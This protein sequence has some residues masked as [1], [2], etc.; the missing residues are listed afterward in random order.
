MCARAASLLLLT[1]TAAGDVRRQR[2][3]RRGGRVCV[4]WCVLPEARLTPDHSAEDGNEDSDDEEPLAPLNPIETHETS[5]GAGNRRGGTPTHPRRRNSDPGQQSSPTQRSQHRYDRR[6]AAVGRYS[7]QEACQS[8]Q[9]GHLVDA[10]APDAGPRKVQCNECCVACSARCR[11]AREGFELQNAQ[12]QERISE[13]EAALRIERTARR[14]AETQIQEM[15]LA[16][17]DGEA[18][19]QLVRR[20]SRANMGHQSKTPSAAAA[21]VAAKEGRGTPPH[22][23]AVA[24]QKVASAP[25]SP[26]RPFSMPGKTPRMPSTFFVDAGNDEL[27]PDEAAGA[28]VHRAHSH[29]PAGDSAKSDQ[30][31]R[32]SLRRRARQPGGIELRPVMSASFLPLPEG[33]ARVQMGET[34]AVLTTAPPSAPAADAAGRRESNYANMLLT[35]APEPASEAPGDATLA[36]AAPTSKAAITVQALAD[37]LLDTWQDGDEVDLVELARTHSI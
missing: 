12:L 26:Q 20:P 5:F 2:G 9:D 16:I 23:S 22:G 25:A 24:L 19:V 36:E 11:A 27:F 30:P 4:P 29:D 34:S 31:L 18:D 3:G 6:V 8:Q 10:C 21:A 17:Q 14:Q 15:L 28:A 13:L 1:A 35:N 32:S 37:G 33:L 7:G